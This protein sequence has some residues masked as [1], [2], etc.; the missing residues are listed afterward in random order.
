MRNILWRLVP[1]LVLV[2]SFSSGIGFHTLQP[3]LAA[4]T[5]APSLTVTTTADTDPT[6]PPCP[7]SGTS[8]Y[9]LRCALAAAASGDT[10]NFN[11]PMLHHRMRDHCQ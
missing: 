7:A 11:I 2:L 3:A 10:I 9:T 5:R 1:A 8:G 6:A 4:S